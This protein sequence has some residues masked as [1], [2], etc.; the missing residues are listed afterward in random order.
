MTTPTV[1]I[2]DDDPGIRTSLSVLLETAQLKTE[3]FALAEDF[4]STYV[5][6]RQGCLLLDVRMPGMSG[7]D[8]QREML[9][10]KVRLPIIFLT[11][12][13]EL[14]TGVDAIKLGA[15]DFLTK[16]INGALLIERVQAAI[17]LDRMQREG[18]AERQK[19]DQ[20]LSKLTDREREVLA[21][22][23]SGMSNRDISTKLRVSARTIEGHRSRILLKAG[24]NSLIELAH[25][26]TVAGVNLA[27]TPSAHS[28]N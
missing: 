17:E 28:K 20:R 13:A 19:I 10:H 18:E 24:F 14:Q 8:V 16:P 25:N 27:N 6:Q 3:C 15:V 2:V 1:F 4:L 23:L 5:P 21:L 7:P 22:A 9:R 12:Y 26:L 11:G